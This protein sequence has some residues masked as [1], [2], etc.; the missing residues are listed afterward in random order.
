MI[1]IIQTKKLQKTQQ[2][3]TKQKVRLKQELNFTGTYFFF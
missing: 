3:T 2:R 1:F